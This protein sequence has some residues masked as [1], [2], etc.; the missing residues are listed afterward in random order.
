V[1]AR[2]RHDSLENLDEQGSMA[3]GRASKLPVQHWSGSESQWGFI[4]ES[5]SRAI[6]LPS[7]T[8]MKSLLFVFHEVE[9]FRSDGSSL[10]NELLV[11]VFL[12]FLGYRHETP[13]EITP[14][15]VFETR[16]PHC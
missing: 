3:A 16:L 5:Q 7:N 15:R 2:E 11:H 6:H 12:D 14:A 13:D 4:R 9:Q 8:D 10:F 1:H